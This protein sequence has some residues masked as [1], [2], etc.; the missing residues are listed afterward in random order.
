VIGSALVDYPMNK[1]IP[2]EAGGKRPICGAKT[3]AGTPCKRAPMP[4]GRCHL[5]GGKSPVGIAASQFKHGR[6]SKYMPARLSERY[7]VALADETMLEQREEIALLGTRLQELLGQL[8][9]MS[10]RDALWQKLGK[11]WSELMT[12]AREGKKEKQQEAANEIEALINGTS[13]DTAV[14]FEIQEVIE[15]RRKLVESERKRM[16]EAQEFVSVEQAMMVAHFLMDSINRHVSNN[17][18]KRA[19]QADLIS[20]YGRPG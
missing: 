1:Q 5:H 8:T 6:Y 3:N 9:D 10:Q 12:A 15:Q 16:V 7:A 18:E 20:V 4:N 17:D 14:W 2:H 11:L 13:N 19:I